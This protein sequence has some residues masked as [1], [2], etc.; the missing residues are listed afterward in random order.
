M[1]I[2]AF[3]LLPTNYSKGMNPGISR[4]VACSERNIEQLFLEMMVIMSYLFNI[5]LII[6]FQVSLVWDSGETIDVSE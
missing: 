2:R 1:L 6:F 3:F 5:V 4:S